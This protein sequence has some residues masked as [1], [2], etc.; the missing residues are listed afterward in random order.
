[1]Y[2]YIYI[3]I[4]IYD[5]YHFFVHSSVD[6]HLICFRIMTIVYNAVMDVGIQISFRILDFNF[7][8]YTP[9]SEIART[10]SSSVFN[11]FEE[12]LYCFP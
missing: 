5:T 1:M 9:R 2:I 3:Y 8:G 12:P 11:F 4:Y 10:Y 6:K 7:F